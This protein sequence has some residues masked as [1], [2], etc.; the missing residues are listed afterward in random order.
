M[1]PPDAVKV[2]YTFTNSGKADE[3]ALVAFPLPD[4][5]GDGDFMVALPGEGLG[6]RCIGRTLLV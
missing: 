2:T 5:T 4:I 3:H 6:L 1:C